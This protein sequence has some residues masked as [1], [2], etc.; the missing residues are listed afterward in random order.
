MSRENLSPNISPDQNAGGQE[1]HRAGI[2]RELKELEEKIIA[3]SRTVKVSGLSGTTI[4][5]AKIRLD[6]ARARKE[7][8]LKE[9]AE[10]PATEEE[11]KAIGATDEEI[12]GLVGSLGPQS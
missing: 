10:L 5:P 11:K 12:E 8:L 6:N 9:I 1:L 4:G 3:S 2:L 7:Q